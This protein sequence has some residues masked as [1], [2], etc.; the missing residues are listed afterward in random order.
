MSKNV[1]DRNRKI[2]HA[3][4]EGAQSAQAASPSAVGAAVS[5][6]G[7]AMEV[8]GKVMG[9][10]GGL[11]EDAVLP[12]MQQLSF[13]QG[14]ACLP[15][16]SHLD[17]V[18]GIDVHFVM[19]PPSPSPIPM[20]HPYIAIVMDPMDWISCAVMSV[21]AMAAPV[22]T[23]DD[24][25]DGAAGLAFGVATMALG[26]MGMG[27]TV[28][29][30][31][32]T[33][34]TTSGVK[35]KT[36]PH[37]PMGASFAPVPVLKNSGHV[38]FGSLFLLADSNPFTGLLHLNNDCWDIGI[39]Q[40]MRKAYPSEPMHL[41]MPTGFVMAIPSH[42]VI[43]NP[44]PTPI[45]PI[46]ALT[47]LLNFGLAKLLHGLVGK[48]PLGARLSNALHK[49]ICHVTGHPVDVASG[50]LFTDEE[51]FSLPGIIPLNWE[52]TWYSDSA[53][54]GPMGH[55]WHHN[56]D[57]GF[58]ANDEGQG[59][60]KMNDGR[61]AVF[62][63]PQPGKSSFNRAEK[64]SLHRHPEEKLYYITDKNGLIYRF[65]TAKYRS[66]SEDREYHL[67]QSISNPNGYAIRFE[68][69]RK[70]YL[71]KI[72]DCA[73]RILS[74]ENDLAG[75]ITAIIAPHPSESGKTFP[76][77]RYEYDEDGNMVCQT[78]A[79]GQ[80]MRYEYNHQ[81]LVKETW[82]D[83]QQW[84]FEYDGQS[85]GARCIHTWGDGD[86][87]NH[88]LT[89]LEGLTLVENSLGHTTSYYLKGG[90]V[91]KKIDANG[92]EWEYRYNRFHELE[93]ETDPLGNQYSYT[94]DERGNI[95]TT[96]DPAGGF[97]YTEYYDPLFPHL[98][99]EAMDAAGGKWKWEY[100]RQ[101]SRTE[102]VT[103]LGA[104]TQ[105]VNSD[106]LLTQIVGGAG[107][108]TE[109][110]Y[111]AEQNLVKII[112]EAD[113]V[114]GYAY[115]RWGNCLEI[116]NPNGRRQLRRYD[117]KRRIVYIADFDGNEIHLDYD[118]L[119]NIIR[120]RDK[121]K[122]V[123]YTYRGL[124]KLTSRT[125]A[126]TTIY[127]NYDT[128]E[129]LRKIVNEQA[130][131]YNF[132]RDPA[133]N[134]V[135][136]T[137]FDGIT[138]DYRRNAAGWITEVDRPA[139]KFTRYD[140][141]PCGRVIEATYSDGG[142]ENYAYRPGGQL[143]KAV[144]EAATV[145]YERDQMG[146]VLKETING[147]WIASEYNRMSQ[148]IR[149][150][151][152]LGADIKNDYD[153]M[154]AVLKMEAN[155]WQAILKY[156]N[157]GLETDRLLP[158]G[159]SS[160]WQR[161]SIGRPVSHKVGH[162]TGKKSISY[163]E[164]QYSWD[165]NDRLNQT[166]DSRGITKFEHDSW[167]NLS[168][169]IFADGEVQIRNPD[170]AGNLY[171]TTDRHD[172]AYG[173]AGQLKRANGWEYTYDAE[174]NLIEKKHAN[175]DTW[176]YTW[177]DAGMLMK[178]VRPD[179][180]EVTFAYD[181]LGRRLWKRYKNT[182]TKFVWD[183]NVPLHEWKEHAVT[184]GKLSESS[185]GSNGLITWIFDNDKFAPAAKIRGDR[186][187]S[188]VTDHLGTPCQMYKDD[189]ALTWD[190]E[191]DSYGK[192]RMEKGETGSC[193]FR[194][195][196]QYED[197]ETGLNYN[198]FRYYAVEEG[199]YISQDPIRLS[200]GNIGFYS[201]VS[202]V[203]KFVDVF[204]LETLYRLL[205]PDED[206]TKGLTAKKP[207]RGMTVH[208]HVSSG[209]RN[210]GS[211]FISTSKDPKYLATTWHQPGQKMVAIDTDKLGP[212]VRVTD[213]STRDKAIANGVGSG[214]ASLPAKSQEV[215]LE[216]HVPAS[217]MQEVDPATFK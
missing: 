166:R 112:S 17:P 177:N 182:S 164:K 138:R 122:D 139:G 160:Q 111:D 24:D 161:D 135:R 102:R 66:G 202:D 145:E 60:L 62:E 121:Q 82:R 33:P 169:T 18:I 216:G 181:A 40:L 154:G 125:E 144:N 212:G 57:I 150:T 124:Y 105:Y 67:L 51:D 195:Q 108:I 5:T 54:Q 31:S 63:L 199:G 155:G 61:L 152:S 126:D 173:K 47:N 4:H 52:R 13:M 215:L 141:D 74:V 208:G 149:T 118:G 11:A 189:G 37:F 128:E 157:Q 214:S 133:G 130:L 211:Q 46:A 151:S 185:V 115:D 136:E 98:P 28:K 42:N 193:P 58:S 198:R 165:F 71:I 203:N 187:Y 38:Q 117:L 1:V 49:S 137:G 85:T 7:T 92:A 109:F 41:Y 176:L 178:V 113:S 77:A 103:P 27:A 9:F 134:V 146:N 30:G 68:Y 210:K 110:K 80:Q 188:I 147:E 159:V 90:L 32:F 93:W 175:G 21:A 94:H 26:M 25:A 194:Y 55:G 104:V 213:I 129:Q 101:G 131:P 140:H 179:K 70:G 167:S 19:I 132:E 106:G 180:T 84:Y 73:G 48:L 162:T 2:E 184:G 89:Y 45:N 119:D 78:D 217:A 197:T 186:Q 3:A 8:Y 16:S 50:L 44:I 192:V 12:I 209:S 96:T 148:R 95:A 158:G 123:S 29:L 39:M 83:A 56:Y 206:M 65:T 91:S 34:R 116:V 201:Y 183:G 171:R 207:N 69:S 163:L 59:I 76:I 190:C 196:G 15:A 87:Y 142:K 35:N 10:T 143:V 97:T 86:L 23:G 153:R 174:G 170:A 79:L 200:S 99:T 120:Y 205:R 168:K 14:I 22:P 204:G 81:L 36:V 88:K 172:R 53:Y 191:L 107:T 156:D 43:V 75:R 100:D 127:F 20:P 114:I 6:A 72:T 64:F